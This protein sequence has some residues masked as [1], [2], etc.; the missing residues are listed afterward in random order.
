VDIDGEVVAFCRK[1]L[2]SW[3]RGA[4][5]DRRFSLRIDDAAKFI[6]ETGEQ[7]DIIICDLPTP[8]EG[9]GP[10]APLYSPAFFRRLA[11]R[12]RPAGILVT[13]AGSGSLFQLRWHTR[14]CRQLKSVFKIVR[15][16]Y[17]FVPSFDVPWGFLIASRGADPWR[18]SA[19]QINRRLGTTGSRLKFYDGETHE[20]LF[21]IPKYARTMLK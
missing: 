15:P 3:H 17:A 10:L 7:F 20:G 2:R 14:L 12:M 16:F 1:Y 5:S 21:R 19:A 6:R 13:Q 9:R 11:A 4:F 8:P 18:A